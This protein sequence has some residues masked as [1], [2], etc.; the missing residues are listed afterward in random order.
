[1]LASVAW[2]CNE[3]IV[4]SFQWLCA[5]INTVSRGVILYFSLLN[6]K[7][8]TWAP[9]KMSKFSFDKERSKDNAGGSIDCDTEQCAQHVFFCVQLATPSASDKT[10]H[11]SQR[12]HSAAYA[13]AF[14]EG[15]AQTSS[16]DSPGNRAAIT[17]LAAHR[18]HELV[19]AIH[20]GGATPT[21]HGKLS[22][23]SHASA[24]AV[25]SPLA[26]LQ[27]AAVFAARKLAER[28]P[29]EA[30][31]DELTAQVSLAVEV[32]RAVQLLVDP[33][34]AGAH[35]GM[36]GMPLI[37]TAM[38]CIQ[39][40]LGVNQAALGRLQQHPALACKWVRML[41]G[42]AA[43]ALE[44]ASSSSSRWARQ[45]R[46]QLA[47]VLRHALGHAAETV[48][49]PPKEVFADIGGTPAAPGEADRLAASKWQADALAHLCLLPQLLKLLASLGALR[50]FASQQS[51]H[52]DSRTGN[53]GASAEERVDAGSIWEEL[54]AAS[55]KAA[56]GRA[57]GER[58]NGC[59]NA[60]LESLGIGLNDKAAAP[61]QQV[62]IEELDSVK[63][64]PRAAK[65]RAAARTI[66]AGGVVIE[67]LE[68][69]SEGDGAD[70]E[71]PEQALGALEMVT[72]AELAAV[73]IACAAQSRDA[74]LDAPWATE[75]SHAAAGRALQALTA[76]A[77]A[78]QVGLQGV[79]CPCSWVACAKRLLAQPCSGMVTE[80][81]RVCCRDE[82]G[83]RG[84]GRPG[85][86]G[87]P[88]PHNAPA[89]R[90]VAAAARRA[91]ADGRAAAVKGAPG[92]HHG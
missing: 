67:E 36:H 72:Q 40:L 70:E 1:M 42:L 87:S 13:G 78:P 64:P 49:S 29:V 56:S 44:C 68:G 91:L 82:A 62:L 51:Q 30:H 20:D 69:S 7:A 18:L 89:A 80:W 52:G 66:S 85:Q 75:A 61:Q 60:G 14:V 22:N 86:P 38:Q 39:Q 65:Q 58:A 81:V 10:S 53:G 8:K 32:A 83:A 27:Q 23:G 45:R 35:S 19:T 59:H 43:C 57:P 48:S 25:S 34:H 15:K 33:T 2:G 63:E 55:S 79:L 41:C 3:V 77:G 74:R 46:P 73:L 26:S 4:S 88:G 47:A 16:S 28:L 90:R 6:F 21:G 76:H 12:D 17:R 84:Q 54:R 5:I 24:D 92:G 9:A 31:A 11:R 37:A 50:P 71:E